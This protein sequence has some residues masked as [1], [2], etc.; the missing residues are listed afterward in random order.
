MC[1]LSWGYKDLKCN[2]R[3]LLWVDTPS[4]SRAAVLYTVQLFALRLSETGGVYA[5]SPKAL[6]AV[7][8]SDEFILFPRLNLNSKLDEKWKKEQS[9]PSKWQKWCKLNV[10]KFKVT[11][12]KIV[13][14]IIFYDFFPLVSKCIWVFILHLSVL[15]SI[16]T[17]FTY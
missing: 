6:W 9:Y 7:L 15:L 12:Q 2:F 13:Y 16:F 5:T 10:S 3:E 4:D 8:R 11:S 1:L 17:C 14:N